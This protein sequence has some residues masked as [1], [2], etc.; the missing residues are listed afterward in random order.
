MLQALRRDSPAEAL[1][2]RFALGPHEL[3][4]LVAESL[5]DAP[6]AG[7]EPEAAA[8]GQALLRDL[9]EDRAQPEVDVE[10]RVRGHREHALGP[11]E[12]RR[13]HRLARLALERLRDRGATGK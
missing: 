1:E 6:V 3:P 5:A 12:V 11:V 7:V 10:G 8:I 13:R 4:H 2:R 9:A